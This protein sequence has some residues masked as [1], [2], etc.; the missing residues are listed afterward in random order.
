MVTWFESDYFKHRRKSGEVIG[1]NRMKW[2]DRA[3]DVYGFI[4][5]WFFFS[6]CPSLGFPKKQEGVWGEADD[7]V[8]SDNK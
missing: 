8:D 7:E 3:R 5:F 4:L 2:K 1:G 6:I